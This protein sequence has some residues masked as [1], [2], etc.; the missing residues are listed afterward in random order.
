MIGHL[1]NEPLTLHRISSTTLDAYGDEVAGE[2]GP[3]LP[4]FGYL[5]QQGSTEVTLDRDT[6][7]SQWTAYLPAGTQVG[8]RDRLTNTAG[9]TFEV[10][11]QPEHCYNPRL[12]TVSHLRLHLTETGLAA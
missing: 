7:V 12:R 3:G 8:Y 5:E 10:A 6:V 4:V 9:Q 2:A 1:L 11:G